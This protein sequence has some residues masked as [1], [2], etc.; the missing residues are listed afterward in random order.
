[1]NWNEASISG[2]TFTSDT[3]AVVNCGSSASTNDVGKLTITGGTF[4]GTAGSVAKAAGA[5][6]PL[7]PAVPSPAM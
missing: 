5:D 4:A 6:D 2:G 3:Y 1:M 7:S